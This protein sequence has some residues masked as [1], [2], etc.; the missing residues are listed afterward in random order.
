MTLL[1]S[2]SPSAPPSYFLSVLLTHGLFPFLKLKYVLSYFK[3]C[4][5]ADPSAKFVHPHPPSTH[6]PSL[7]HIHLTI[8]TYF[9]VHLK[10][11]FHLAAFPDPHS[12][13]SLPYFFRLGMDLQ[14]YNV[15][16]PN[17]PLFIALTTYNEII[18]LLE[19]N[20]IAE[21]KTSG[22]Q[23]LCLFYSVFLL[24]TRVSPIAK[25][26]VELEPL[27]AYWLM[28]SSFR[29]KTLLTSVPRETTW[30]TRDGSLFKFWNRTQSEKF[31]LPF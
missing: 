5:Y 6:F 21:I 12:S 14:W 31:F 4:R 7:P 15:K 13:P 10:S 25:Q 27:D 29:V 17:F 20:L 30:G 1:T 2:S 19:M 24:F 11:Q 3:A 22:S 26:C 18:Q 9:R 8:P 28:D 16:A 23:R